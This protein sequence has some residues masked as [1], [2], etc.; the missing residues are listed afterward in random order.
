MPC[1][2]GCPVVC[3]FVEP[4]FRGRLLFCPIYSAAMM[5]VLGGSWLLWQTGCG[6]MVTGFLP[7]FTAAPDDLLYGMCNHNV[8][9]IPPSHC[10]DIQFCGFCCCLVKRV[11]D[12]LTLCPYTFAC[13][14]SGFA[15]GRQRSEAAHFPSGS[16]A[17]RATV[18]RYI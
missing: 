10:R 8:G 5:V 16:L 7:R 15:G 4:D 13:R 14:C 3:L 9:I 18:H 12:R 11:E 1:G 6:T 2:C 17:R